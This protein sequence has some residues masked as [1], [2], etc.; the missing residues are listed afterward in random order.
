MT[1]RV[2]KILVCIEPS[3][4]VGIEI[5]ALA[6]P[7]VT[8]EMG[9]VRYVDHETTEGLR[10]K[11]AHDQG[12]DI[13]KIVDVDYVWGSQSLAELVGDEALF[14]YVVAS[15]V[16]EH[17]PDFIGW[18]KEIRAILKPD[19]I[20][21]LVIP[22]KQYCFDYY[23]QLTKPADVVE[24]YLRGARKPSPRQIYDFLSSA[25]SWKGAIAWKGEI[26]ENELVQIHSEAEA[27]ETAKRVFVDDTYHDV[28][29]WVF[30][31]YSLFELFRT[32]IKLELFDFKIA[33][34]YKTDG[35]EFYV[36]L[37]ALSFSSLK[38]WQH[39]QL[40]SLPVL[41][42]DQLGHSN[43]RFELGR[44]REEK[45]LT[46]AKLQKTQAELERL[47]SQIK[48]FNAQLE[49]K[50]S[51][52]RKLRSQVQNIKIRLKDSQAEIDAMKASKFWKLRTQW[53][54]LKKL[55]SSGSTS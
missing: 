33:K 26:S 19:G 53:F 43:L 6:N 7:I 22:D 29:C 1:T 46:Q 51:L 47:Q 48:Q 49:Q 23:R 17:V 39:I 52:T 14:D 54:K 9:T 41:K 20:L 25:V 55:L 12:V 4:Q 28:H 30:T 2:E 42:P 44:E 11:Y 31:P 16:I 15:H 27:W 50:R 40:E 36:S 8:R 35:C 32:L 21:S 10:T 45:L 3:T 34:F 5:G 37:Q 18:L 24:A 13:N 38:N